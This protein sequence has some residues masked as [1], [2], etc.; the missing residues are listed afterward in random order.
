MFTRHVHPEIGCDSTSRH[1]FITS[2]NSFRVKHHF[3]KL[4]ARWAKDER[5]WYFPRDVDPTRIANACE[6][7]NWELKQVHFKDPTSKAGI[8]RQ[9][10][11]ETNG[12]DLLQ[13]PHP[14]PNREIDTT[15]S[16]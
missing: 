7:A 8:K 9:R 16:V 12:V 10:E 4:K 6:Q 11:A 5:R 2:D 13:V 14:C 1:W 3:V 15:F